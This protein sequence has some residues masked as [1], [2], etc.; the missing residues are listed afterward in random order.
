M[1]G[2]RAYEPGVERVGEDKLTQVIVEAASRRLRDA[3]TPDVAI[4][5]AG[6]AGLTAAWL[7]AEKGLRVTVFE[8]GLGT[9]GG[10][11]GGSSLLP[12]GL[13]AEGPGAEIARR[14][15]VRL[16]ETG[17]E[18]VYAADPV[19]L[20]AKLTAR[21]LDA[22][23]QIIVGAY[24]EDLIVD[25][26]RPPR[27]R[28]LVVVLSP[29]VGAGW[30][31]DPVYAPARAVLDATGHDASLLRI[32]AKR[33]PGLLQV[34]G[35]ASLDTWRGEELVVEKTGRVLPGLY[36]AGMAVAEYYNTPRMG[37]VFSGMLASGAKAAEEIARD[38]ARA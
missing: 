35:M 24:V 17:V 19:E 9:G 3:L 10:M 34:P 5:G 26:G 1:T 29:A 15:G 20:V 30:H 32:L 37:P 25:H 33:Y 27:V 11:R 7:L 36:V 8:R 2:W 21:A 28:G 14:A 4:A 6:P 16:E 31:I 13:I 23:A 22:G 38:L 18:G 12:V